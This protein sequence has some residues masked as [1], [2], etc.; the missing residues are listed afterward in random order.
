MNILHQFIILSTDTLP[1]EVFQFL[2]DSL[3]ISVSEIK[4]LPTENITNGTSSSIGIIAVA[5]IFVIPLLAILYLIYRFLTLIFKRQFNQLFYFFQYQPN[6]KERN[7]I[8][9]FLAG[10]SLYYIQLTDVLKQK[11]VKRFYSFYKSKTYDFYYSEPGQKKIIFTACTEMTRITFGFS[12]FQ[13]IDF[14]DFNFYPQEYAL[15]GY[16]QKAYGHTSDSG[17][18]DFS[19]PKMEAGIA[20]LNDGDNLLLHELAHAIYIQKTAIDFDTRYNKIYDVWESF[21]K[22]VMEKV[23]EGEI[24]ILRNYAFTNTNEML[25]V[26]TEYF[27]EKPLELKNEQPEMFYFMK[28]LYNQNTLD[29]LS[30][31][32]NGKESFKEIWSD[33]KLENLNYSNEAS[34]LKLENIRKGENRSWTVKI[35]GILVM[36]LAP[37]IFYF[38]QIQNYFLY[39]LI[40]I[41]LSV[42]V[43][44]VR[45]KYQILKQISTTR[46]SYDLLIEVI[47]ENFM[48]IIVSLIYILFFFFKAKIILKTLF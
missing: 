10:N 9:S 4:T 2:K 33:F 6:E 35:M 42:L 40:S 39:F 47:A 14:T 36:F 32:L 7:E 25:A 17:Y 37:P 34:I 28:Y 27:F 11:F 19:T 12:E 38:L 22:Y 44:M 29:K 45:E 48:S 5:L 18:I 46:P 30:P 23:S 13:L 20:I 24:S 1:S 16:S 15:K 21:A 31:I 3:G 8:H 41:Y 26:S 43:F